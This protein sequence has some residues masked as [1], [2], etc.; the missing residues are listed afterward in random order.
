MRVFENIAC[1]DP[2]PEFDLSESELSFLDAEL[3]RVVT[4]LIDLRLDKKATRQYCE[5][6]LRI[7][8]RKDKYDN[9]E[10]YGMP[11]DLSQQPFL[12]NPGEVLISEKL[13]HPSLLSVIYDDR[14]SFGNL[15]NLLKYYQNE[16]KSSLDDW[17]DI[18]DGLI[19]YCVTFD[20]DDIKQNSEKIEDSVERTLYL[21]KVLTE[22]KVS[23]LV[24][25]DHKHIQTDVEKRIEELIALSKKMNMLLGDGVNSTVVPADGNKQDK[26][27]T[28]DKR[29]DS[30][31]SNK[32]YTPNGIALTDTYYSPEILGTGQYTED[33]FDFTCMHEFRQ[34]FHLPE[35]HDAILTGFKECYIEENGIKINYPVLYKTANLID[36]LCADYIKRIGELHKDDADTIRRK[37]TEWLCCTRDII[38]EIYDENKAVT[39]QNGSDEIGNRNYPKCS[40]TVM[41]DAFIDRVYSSYHSHGWAFFGSVDKTIQHV[42]PYNMW[43]DGYDRDFEKYQNRIALPDEDRAKVF[44][45]ANEQWF[46]KEMN[47]YLDDY[48]TTCGCLHREQYEEYYP[49]L[50][51]PEYLQ[52]LFAD[53]VRRV[54]NAT[55]VE[56]VA[57]DAF[58][59]WA[60]NIIALLSKENRNKLRN[61][62]KDDPDDAY[63]A[64]CRYFYVR[65]CLPAATDILL[66]YYSDY[67]EINANKVL[68]EKHNVNEARTVSKKESSATDSPRVAINTGQSITTS[69]KEVVRSWLLYGQDNDELVNFIDNNL[70]H[71]TGCQAFIYIAA[72]IE[73]QII[74]KPPFEE[75]IQA[76]PNI[77]KK[78]NYNR[79]LQK[80]NCQWDKCTFNALK[81]KFLF[82]KQEKR[83]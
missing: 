20:F 73:A 16:R 63:F 17:E 28:G 37:L 29:G 75:L 27:Q 65:C 33:D 56:T 19:K 34:R 40:T 35:F 57:H 46:K 81:E 51:I 5:K 66:N 61:L 74:G 82:Y 45:D 43:G 18:S 8:Y 2:F 48:E 60:F 59:L 26:E 14:Y 4:D 36:S 21:E 69:S 23:R 49:E 22:S 39:P 47:A 71:K 76:Y 3:R 50:H 12:P 64:N 52:E 78:N 24:D 31:L 30:V 32:Y 83:S 6:Y 42:M 70:S 72:A 44:H 77:G 58:Q 53:Y 41:M 15:Y 25:D 9:P 13:F 54:H 1:Y 11:F 68:T 10:K 79:Q 7:D 80:E 55:D 38:L 62:R 67:G